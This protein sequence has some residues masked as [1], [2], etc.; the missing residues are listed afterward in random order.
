MTDAS[1]A[2]NSN[3]A[4]RAVDE[5]GGTSVNVT[6]GATVS[7]GSVAVSTV[8]GGGDVKV[9]VT[10]V[11]TGGATCFGRFGVVGRRRGGGADVG[12][13]VLGGAAATVVGGALGAPCAGLVG[14][15]VV[16]PVGGCDPVEREGSLVA[17]GAVVVCAGAAG[18]TDRRAVGLGAVSWVVRPRS[19]AVPTPLATS[20]A[21]APTATATAAAPR[22]RRSAAHRVG[23]RQ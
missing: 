14:A 23:P 1:L 7:G 11:V 8:V 17:A 6:V 4:A 15:C 18:G 12:V 3:R 20:S 22:G 19:V 10:A 16:A 21:A 5:G 2:T 13:C 9:T